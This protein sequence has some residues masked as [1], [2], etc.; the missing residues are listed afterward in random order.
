MS[1]F[2][3]LVYAETSTTKFQNNVFLNA[4]K[5]FKYDVP[6]TF[7]ALSSNSGRAMFETGCRSWDGIVGRK[8]G[9][10]PVN[11][12]DC[13]YAYGVG[14]GDKKVKCKQNYIVYLKHP[15]PESRYVM[16]LNYGSTLNFGKYAKELSRKGLE[17]DQVETIITKI[18]NPDGVGSI[19]TFEQGE[20]L[21]LNITT[22]E[23]KALN[24]I[25]LKAKSKGGITVDV[26]VEILLN[27]EELEGLDETRA[28]RLAE[29][30]AKDGLIGV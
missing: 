14:E 17:P 16:I 28:T 20:I 23:Q 15:D 2:V 5:D 11:C 22:E 9:E 4:K 27:Y 1:K 10:D 24:T 25:K 26:A 12:K 13:A 30:I 8:K 6:K 7:I 21:D 29:S 3:D 19:F 18:E